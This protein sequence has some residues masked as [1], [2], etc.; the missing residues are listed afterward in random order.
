MAFDLGGDFQEGVDLLGIGLPAR[1]PLHHPPHPAG[2]FAARRALA[3]ALVL[4]EVA[5]AGDR[6]DQVGGLVHHDHR[7]GAEA[8]LQGRQGVEVHRQVL[9]DLRRDHAHRRAARDHRLEVAPPAPHAAAVILDQLAE[10][11]RHDLLHVARPLDVA[12]DAEQ[13]GAGVVGAAEAGEPVRAAAQD[14]RDHRDGFHVVDRGR[15]A[16]EARAGREW[17][18]QARLALLA[19]QALQEGGLFAA[20]VGPGAVVDID[21]EIPAVDV[22]LAD[23]LGLVGLL[24][25]GLHDLALTH[26][27]AA[28]VDVAGVGLHR[29]AGDQAPLDE[30]VRVMPHDLAV[31]AGARL[32]LVGVDHQVV[33]TPFPHLLGHERPLQAGREACA[34]AAAQ[35]RGLGVV[36]D[37]VAPARQD[38]L[39]QMP[40]AALLGGLQAPVMEAVEVGEDAVFVF[41]DADHVG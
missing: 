29:E 26:V 1:H 6:L 39:G 28:D 32:G 10:G 16:V 18:L 5:D 30:Q 4:V 8:G 22:V 3:A 31:L 33:G 13:L 20:D 27:F 19:F 24:D 35:A 23:Q 41:E 2:A 40:G 17:R 7:R 38:V 14:G 21:V 36:D 25:R 12:G 15:A 9:A 34:A 11:D 37:P